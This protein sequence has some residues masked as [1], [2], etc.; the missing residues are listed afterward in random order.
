MSTMLK[1]AVN[2]MSAV[3]SRPDNLFVVSGYYLL[4]GVGFLSASFVALFQ[5]IAI[6]W[7]MIAGQ[8]FYTIGIAMLA[9]LT[10]ASTAL[11]A[12]MVFNAINLSMEKRSA[13]TSTI[14]LSGVTVA[15]AIVT[16][17][18]LWIA[19]PNGTALGNAL[20]ILALAIAA[21]SALS[22]WYLMRINVKR[23]FESLA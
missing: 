11:G 17:L 6:T 12:S 8:N 16:A 15:A 18:A 21:C 5:T 9:L 19:N 13:R 22:G 14:A 3:P 7:Y 1:T 20:I 2:T 23:Y 10:M 4:T